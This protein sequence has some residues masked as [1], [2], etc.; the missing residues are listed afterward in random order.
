[1]SEQIQNNFF[2]FFLS[3]HTLRIFDHNLQMHIPITLKLGTREGLI[4]AH[5]RTN[6]G[7]NPIKIYGV[8]IYFSCRK[9]SKVC[10][11]YR[12]NHWEELDETWHVGGVTTKGTP[13]MVTPP[14]CQVLSN[15][16]Q[17]FTL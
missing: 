10:D 11:A 1:M 2:I 5:L 4:K 8:M 13:M 12:V 17:W 3:F 7:W 16:F 14:T 9:R 6:F 15:S